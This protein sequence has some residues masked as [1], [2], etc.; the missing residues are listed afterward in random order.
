MSTVLPKQ[1]HAPWCASRER[2][3]A[4]YGTTIPPAILKHTRRDV[5]RPVQ[6]ALVV[7][8][9]SAVPIHMGTSALRTE[10]FGTAGI[11]AVPFTAP[12]QKIPASFRVSMPMGHSCPWASIVF[13]GVE[14]VI[15]PEGKML[16]PAIGPQEEAAM[17]SAFHVR[18]V[19]ALRHAV[20]DR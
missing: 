16:W 8:I 4:Q 7:G 13:P 15:A 3:F 19:F 5:F 6:A 11:R 10:I 17:L 2:R 18:A 20:Q 14:H 1:N 12:T 9:P